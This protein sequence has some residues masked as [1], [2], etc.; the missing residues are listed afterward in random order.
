[1]EFR[2]ENDPNES[3]EP[4]FNSSL[5]Q[6]VTQQAAPNGTQQTRM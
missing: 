2:P 4:K 5:R 6:S 3:I 1:M